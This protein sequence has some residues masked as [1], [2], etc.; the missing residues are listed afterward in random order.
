M[1]PGGYP[2]IDYLAERAAKH[3]CAQGAILYAPTNVALPPHVSRVRQDG[4]LIISLLLEYFP[5]HEIIFRPYPTAQ[6][7]DAVADLLE[8][9]A[10]HDRFTLDREPTPTNSQLRSVLSISDVSSVSLSFAMATLRPFVSCELSNRAHNAGVCGSEHGLGY[11]AYNAEQLVNA[12]RDIIGRPQHWREKLRKETSRYVYNPGCSAQYIAEH[13]GLMAQGLAHED[14]LKVAR[15]SSSWSL[16]TAREYADHIKS[17]LSSGR[18]QPAER[19]LEH[20]L[21][22]FP[23]DKTLKTLASSV[24]GNA[25]S[26]STS[27]TSPPALATPQ[28]LPET[29]NKVANNTFASWARGASFAATGFVAD[30]WYSSIGN[31]GG[32]G[33]V[34]R[35]EFAEERTT[36]SGDARYYLRFNQI[37]AGTFNYLLQTVG[38]ADTCA[39]RRVTLSF[40]ARSDGIRR[41]SKILLVQRFGEGGSPHASLQVTADLPITSV[42]NRY[43]FDVTLPDI[44]A[45][46]VGDGNQLDLIVYTNYAA[47]ENTGVYDFANVQMTE[48][49]D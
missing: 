5:D 36:L 45:K 14:W 34:S 20:A 35:Q 19:N 46:T 21:V 8:E 15:A 22:A 25:A 49:V 30:S 27:K 39:G 42:W 31:N 3:D 44:G 12:V 38:S 2:K 48:C 6:N 41:L 18:T 1:I 32:V 16:D 24:N 4:R 9:Y 26:V 13:I 10:G 37:E 28:A 29:A 7:L 40:C 43:S 23:S 17:L 33:V 11:T 47:P